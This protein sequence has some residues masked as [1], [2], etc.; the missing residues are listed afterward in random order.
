MVIFIGLT[1]ENL[2]FKIAERLT[3]RKWGMQA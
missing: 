1:V 2:I 3:V